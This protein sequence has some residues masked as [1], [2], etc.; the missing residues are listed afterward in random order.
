[1]SPDSE[2]GRRPVIF[3]ASCPECFT[4]IW[5]DERDLKGEKVV[6]CPYCDTLISL[7]GGALLSESCNR[8][9]ALLEDIE[10]QI[11]VMPTAI[12]VHRFIS[13]Q[14]GHIAGAFNDRLD[15]IQESKDEASSE[16]GQV[17][18]GKKR[19]S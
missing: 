16:S 6:T 18:S 3:W 2:G 11:S 4:Y 13:E 9:Q 19:A 5:V 8:L 14:V 1:M 17:E 7:S 15:E 10:K 12:D